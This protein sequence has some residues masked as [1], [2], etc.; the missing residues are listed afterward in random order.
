M[1]TVPNQVDVPIYPKGYKPE[2]HSLGKTTVPITRSQ[3]QDILTWR[4]HNERMLENSFVSG[5]PGEL[6]WNNGADGTANAS[7]SSETG[8]MV[9]LIDQPILYAGYF[10][11]QP[12]R[13][14]SLLAR[15]IGSST[16]TPT[17]VG[18]WRMGTTQGVATQSGNASIGQN[19]A[20]ATG[21][22]VTNQFW[23][24][25]LDLVCT[26]TGT[27]ANN[28][29]VECSGYIWGSLFVGLM[30]NLIPSS[31]AL[32]TWTQTFDASVNNYIQF[33]WTWSASSASNTATLKHGS[34]YGWK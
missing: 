33:N 9:G 8:M 4:R 26:I 10:Y 23:E 16:G 31:G 2:W 30:A 24:T 22:S 3:W 28:A 20:L 11:V 19:T 29:T 14:V 5:M 13:Q 27:G 12:R 1:W 7:T 15:G 18:Q 25:R 32:A 21:S 34:M 6:M 17:V